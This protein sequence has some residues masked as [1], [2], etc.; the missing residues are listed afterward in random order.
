MRLLVLFPLLA[1]QAALAQP[2]IPSALLTQ[3]WPA[4]WIVPPEVPR[5]AYGVYCFRK[6]L[7]LQEKPKRFVVHV[8]AD[9]RYR[10]F[11]NGVAV[12]LG[13]AR[14]DPAHW[15]YE[16]L[17]LA[18]HLRAGE[19]VLAALVWNAGDGKPL[20][21][22]SW[23]TGFL[24]QGNGPAEAAAHTDESWKVIHNQAY[25]PLPP[26]RAAL[27]TYLVS[28]D[29]DRVE[30]SLHPWGWE[31]PGY[32]DSAW[33]QARAEWFAA[34]PRG[35]GTDGNWLL[36]PREIPLMEERLERLAHVRRAEGLSMADSF[37]Q[38]G[39][40]LSIPPRSRARFLLDQGHLTNAYPELRVSG[41]KGAAIILTYAE[42]L[43]DPNR[44]K[45][46]RDEVEGKS[47]LGVQDQFLPD[48][49]EDRLFRPLW[50]RCYRYIE[51]EVQTGA[52]ALVLHDL[53]GM[54]TGYPFEEKAAFES[55]DPA[56]AAIWRAGWRTARL[57]AGET[58]MDCPYY[59]QLQYAGD[60]RIQALISLYVS[61]DDRLMR[62]AI[63]DFSHS[64]IPEGLTQ[65]RYPCN[66]PQ[67]IPTY[68][69]FWISMLHDYWMHRPDAAFVRQHLKGVHDI[70]AWFEARRQPGGMMGRAEW[71]NFVDWAWPWEESTRMGG[72]PPGVLEG[73]SS[74]LSLHYAW[75]LRQAAELCLQAGE[76]EAAVRYRRRVE[77]ICRATR[78]QCW[79]AGRSLLADTPAKSSFSEHAQVLGVLAGV[80]QQSEAQALM[81][82]L[83]EEEGLTPCTFYFR[84]YS[85]EALRQAGLGD[86]FLDELGPWKDMLALGL[87]TFAENPEPTRSDCHAWSASPVYELLATVCGIRPAAPGFRRVQIAPNL[88]GLPRVSG[89]MPHP[90]GMIEVEF[91]QE[92]GKLRGSVSLPPG[93][94]GELRWAGK[95]RRLPPG[96]TVL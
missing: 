2:A 11:V 91:W 71:W 25:A 6:R 40:S 19:N 42:A 62:K 78:A 83:P 4:R 87:S 3:G 9:N 12:S 96:R 90:Q 88:G 13:P 28:G 53:Y 64:F 81:S 69:L 66:D 8:S 72:V 55:P 95:R 80:F 86:R 68:S 10:L 35:V 29:G 34:K 59:E 82:R 33:P 17:D 73:G 16:T 5:S 47:I 74:I 15:H 26:D 41:G 21:Q 30:G 24:M 89:R 54:F 49:G 36:T 65:S 63:R 51:L 57:C 94:E 22:M 50:W 60:A 58:Y 44:Q 75:T 77:E 37:L 52:E 43:L 32:D 7:T 23:Q 39:A 46:K 1:L 92:E 85:F 20:A 61:G 14:S 67:V 70:L 48:G 18:A 76:R 56:L 27:Q 84:F 31:L 38:G 79:D 93:V 45:G